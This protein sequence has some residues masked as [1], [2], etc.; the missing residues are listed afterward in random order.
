M[1]AITLSNSVSLVF[2]KLHWSVDYATKVDASHHLAK[3]EERDLVDHYGDLSRLIPALTQYN[4]ERDVISKLRKT[5]IECLRDIKSATTSDKFNFKNKIKWEVVQGKFKHTVSTNKQHNGVLINLEYNTGHHKSE[6]AAKQ[7]FTA[8]N[9]QKAAEV[10]LNKTLMNVIV[11]DS[12]DE[13][14]EHMR[15][16]TKRIIDSLPE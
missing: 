4:V 16:E 13:F 7:E 1:T 8:P 2:S 12:L 9:H 11:N 6:G 14:V 15:I 5:Y 3:N 10:L